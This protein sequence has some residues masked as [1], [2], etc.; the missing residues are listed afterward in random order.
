[1]AYH[2]L[3]S[4][5][6]VIRDLHTGGYWDGKGEFKGI[7]LA[8]KYSRTCKNDIESDLE[9]ASKVS[10]YGVEKVKVYNSPKI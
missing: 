8:E 1:M 7:L 5:Y 9:E 3:D 4:I 2:E 6:F 10:Q